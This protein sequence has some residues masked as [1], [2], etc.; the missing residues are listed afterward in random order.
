[1]HEPVY[2]KLTEALNMKGWATPAIKCPESSHAGGDGPGRRRYK[3]DHA[4]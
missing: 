2:E 3:Y 4:S 1:M